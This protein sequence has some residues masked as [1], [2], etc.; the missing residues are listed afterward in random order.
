[1]I[2]TRDFTVKPQALGGNRVRFIASTA[3]VDAQRTRILPRGCRLDRFKAAGSLPLLWA[4]K[5]DGAPDDVLGRV[6][7]VEVSDIAVTCT[8]EFEAHPRAQMV[9]GMVRRGVLR[10]C[11][12]GFADYEPSEPDADGVS[13]I[14]EWTLCELSVCPVG[15][16]PEALAVRAFTVRT[17]AGPPQSK[18]PKTAARAATTRSTRM[19]P[20]DKLGLKEGAAPEEVAAALIK[21]LK[22]SADGDEDKLALVV[23]LLGML[24]PAA[25]DDGAEATA[26]AMA[27]EVKTLTA[28][29]AELEAQKD[30]PAESPEQ[31]AERAIASG[32]WPVGQRAALVAEYAAGRKPFLLAERTFAARQYTYTAGGKPVAQNAA[33]RQPNLG[34]DTA[35]V[36]NRAAAS[37][38]AVLKK[39]GVAVTPEQ[40]AAAAQ[41]AE[42][43]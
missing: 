30:A 36:E 20:L 7:E 37:T 15:A 5:R 28:R 16:N 43:E 27:E 18:T 42:Q 1:M 31:Q 2:Q 24:A 13:T 41:R 32:R 14:A 8:A 19:N 39:L 11:S 26:K 35:A 33:Q 38:M 17:A 23:A 21:Y 9:L 6:V 34:A 40:F 25:S 4:H 3:A 10:G 12:I 29:V 22:E